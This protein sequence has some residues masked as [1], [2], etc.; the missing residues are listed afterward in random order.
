MQKRIELI[1]SGEYESFYPK[2]RESNQRCSGDKLL[3]KPKTND[4]DEEKSS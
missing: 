1:N 2:H 3:F 4:V